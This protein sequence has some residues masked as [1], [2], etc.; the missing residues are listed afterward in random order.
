MLVMRLQFVDVGFYVAVEIWI[1]CCIAWCGFRY[2][3]KTTLLEVCEQI[4]VFRI[5]DTRIKTRQI[6]NQV[7]GSRPDRCG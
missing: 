4:F 3:Q 6:G 1:F 7:Q 5:S 2:I